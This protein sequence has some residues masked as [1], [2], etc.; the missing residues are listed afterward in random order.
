MKTLLLDC[1]GVL[2]DCESQVHKIALKAT[3][4]ELP[5]P[6]VWHTF[7]FEEAMGLSRSEIWAFHDEI[8]R[9]DIGYN[10]QAYPGAV[11][12]VDW[13]AERFD[14]CFVT[15]HWRGLPHWV[16]AREEVISTFFGA[17]YDVIFAHNKS[18]V[19]GDHLVDDKPATL[20]QNQHRAIK[21]ARPWNREVAN[22]PTATNY[23]ELKEL[24]SV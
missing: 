13:A 16:P 4:R 20:I 23:E 3:R 19:I 2:L 9:S 11:E 5:G 8:E 17:H 15:S 18:R 24:L 12:F 14:V 10:I 21:F 22:V 7:E 1:D 6:A